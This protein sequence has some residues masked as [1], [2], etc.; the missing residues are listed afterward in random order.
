MRKALFNI[1]AA[2]MLLC[3]NMQVCAQ[4]CPLSSLGQNPATA[5]PV[6][7]SGSFTQTSVNLCGGRQVPNP[8]CNTWVLADLNPYWYKFTCFKSGTLGFIIMPNSA[9]SDY[10]WQVFDVTNRNPADVYTDVSMSICSN[11]SERFG[12]TGTSFTAT[13]LFECEGPTPQFS[14]MPNL[15]Q[16]HV[17]LLLISHFTN[18]SA[19]YQLQFGG[20][21]AVITDTTPPKLQAVYTNCGMGQIKVKL[22]KRMKCN[23][24]AANGS[25]F[26]LFPFGTITA[27]TGIGCSTGFDTDSILLTLQNDLPPG[28]Y[29]LRCRNGSDGNTLLDYCDRAMPI[30]EKL[31][32]TIPFAPVMD[33]LLPVAKTCRP[34]TLQLVFKEPVMCNSAAA[35]GSDFTLSGPAAVNI[36]GIRFTCE[37]GLTNHIKLVLNKPITAGGIYTIALQKGSDGNTLLNVCNRP[38]VDTFLRFVVHDTVSAAF[39]HTLRS[40]C[41]TD[42][43]RFANAGLNGIHT[44]QWTFD[45]TGGSTVQNPVRLYVKKGNMTARLVVS[46]GVCTDSSTQQF[47][48]DGKH[49]KAAF[50]AT[51]LICPQDTAF[52]IDSSTG[53]IASWAWYFDNG[54]TASD[55]V[56][57]PQFYTTNI[58]GAKVCR[59]ML[60]VSDSTGCSDTTYRHITIAAN[61]TIAVPTGFTP[62]NDGLNDKLYPLNAYKALNLVFKVYNRYG[63]LVWQ[64]TDWTKQWDGRMN[65]IMQNGGIF[66]WTLTYV[67]ADTG[68]A[69]SQKGTTVLIH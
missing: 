50:N 33:S 58:T 38:A 36:A 56:P 60:V 59:P 57:A 24:L 9:F 51:K 43:M 45:S 7:G 14:R 53:P 46:N 17:Y 13:G 25:D 52:F 48:L 49:I 21:S 63:Q 23:S 22:N 4:T 55:P 16:G 37:N 1:V 20:G 6:C 67:H 28:N 26:E 18:S 29:E 39:T 35:D 27:A 42:T 65:G 5:F 19:G 62:N 11:W 15:V 54:K 31:P 3:C 64:T 34:D 8:M 68:K 40:N 44:W 30:T 41:V 66:V 32:F 61:C 12:A 10:D 2:V 47:L 69:V